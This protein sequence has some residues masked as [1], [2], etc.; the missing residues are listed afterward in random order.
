MKPKDVLNF[1]E[2]NLNFLKQ[3][4]LPTH[5]KEQVGLRIFLC[6]DCNTNGKCTHCGCKTPNMFYAPHKEDALNRW[7]TFLS[8]KQWEALKNN[9]DNYKQYI[10]G[11]TQ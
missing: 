7:S 5:I 1:V 10:D 8:E 2:G 4:S 11:L 3:E 9:I 6:Q